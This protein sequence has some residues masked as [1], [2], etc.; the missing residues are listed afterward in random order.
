MSQLWIFC[1]SICWYIAIIQSRIIC[2]RSNCGYNNNIP[3]GIGDDD[4][5]VGGKGVGTGCGGEG[6]RYG[7]VGGV[8]IAAGGAATVQVWE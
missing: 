3:I 5:L 6:V 4:G 7:G 1:I 2:N 8:G